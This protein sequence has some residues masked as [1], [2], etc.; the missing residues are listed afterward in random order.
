MLKSADLIQA[1][2]KGRHTM[3]TAPKGL[4]SRRL[5]EDSLRLVERACHEQIAWLFGLNPDL[6]CSHIWPPAVSSANPDQVVIHWA[7]NKNPALNHS[8]F[9]TFRRDH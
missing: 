6:H 1:E 2:V 7:F 5:D 4:V 3:D 8:Q 9:V